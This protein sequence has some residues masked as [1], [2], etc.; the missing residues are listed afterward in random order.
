MEASKRL[1]QTFASL[2]EDAAEEARDRVM[3]MVV[4]QEEE[5][6]RRRPT[7]NHTW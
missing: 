7:G 5:Q 2:M 1:R 3:E 4:G 6:R